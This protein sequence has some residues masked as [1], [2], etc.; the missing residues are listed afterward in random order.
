MPSRIQPTTK[1]FPEFKNEFK[2]RAG[3]FMF[4]IRGNVGLTINPYWDLNFE[5]TNKQISEMKKVLKRGRPEDF[6]D[7]DCG[8]DCSVDSPP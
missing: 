8:E 3:D 2:V 1:R 7:S 6:S 4:G 5:W